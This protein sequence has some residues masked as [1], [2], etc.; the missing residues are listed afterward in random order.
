MM[1]MLYDLTHAAPPTEALMHI[2]RDGKIVF[3][4]SSSR[5]L[6][7]KSD[8]KVVFKVDSKGTPQRVYVGTRDY[9]AYGVKPIGNRYRVTS[10]RLAEDLAKALEGYG[11]YRIEAENK[12]CG[13]DNKTYYS[14]FFKRYA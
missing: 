4:A 13:Y 1:T 9:S 7:L 10:K 3:N 14:I 11:T 12:V 2:Y 6:G 5:L 8:S